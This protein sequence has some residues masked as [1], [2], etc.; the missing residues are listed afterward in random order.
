MEN[1]FDCATLFNQLDLQGQLS[2]SRNLNKWLFA[3]VIISAGGFVCYYLRT[4]N[5]KDQNEKLAAQIAKLK[6]PPQIIE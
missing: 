1:S 4:Q 6:N 3:I 5:L 2:K